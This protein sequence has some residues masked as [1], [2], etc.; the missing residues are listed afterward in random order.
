MDAE[1]DTAIVH[2]WLRHPK[3]EYWDMLDAT[4][5]DVRKLIDDSFGGPQPGGHFGLR[6]GYFA[7]TPQFLFELYHPPTSDLGRPGTGYSYRPGDLGMHLLVA[8]TDRKLPGFT[9]SVMLHIIR[10]AFFEVGARRVVVEPDVRNLEVQRLNAAVGFR[11]AGD[12]PVAQKIARLSYCT[13]ADFLRDTDHGRT[14]ADADRVPAESDPAESHG[15]A[16]A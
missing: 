15:V 3:A 12:Y 1:R 6:M 13:R 4:P 9:G 16:D 11:V 8:P 10:T 7:G 2:R 5:A 14:L